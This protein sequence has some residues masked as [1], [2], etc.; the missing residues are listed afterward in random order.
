MN[1]DNEK[2]AALGPALQKRFGDS[3]SLTQAKAAALQTVTTLAS[4]ASDVA[5]QL[6]AAEP[7]VAQER[8]YKST[9][10]ALNRNVARMRWYAD[11]LDA[12]NTPAAVSDVLAKARNK[13]RDA[14]NDRIAARAGLLKLDGADCHLQPTS[15]IDPIFAPTFF[16]ATGDTGGPSEAAGSSSEAT[17]AAPGAT[18]GKVGTGTGAGAKAPKDDGGSN[19]ATADQDKTPR[20]PGDGGTPPSD[21]RTGS[22]RDKGSP[23]AT[24]GTTTQKPKQ[25][26]ARTKTKITTQDAPQTFPILPP[27]AGTPS[28]GDTPIKTAPGTTST[29]TTPPPTPQPGTQEQETPNHPVN[30]FVNYHNAMGLGPAVSAGQWV[31]VSCRV[32]D[33]AIGSVNPDGYWYRIASAPWNDTYYVPANTFMNGDPYGGPYTHNTDFAVPVCGG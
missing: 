2:A 13:G 28:G 18:I 8:T 11:A 29:A 4:R 21:D 24:P 33:A 15:T 26:D 32:Y 1:R 3:M 22:Q 9:V 30:T 20:A 17:T 14:S 23:S 27:S 7:P 12:A 6:R 16:A 25:T 19:K 10:N 5:A 31:T